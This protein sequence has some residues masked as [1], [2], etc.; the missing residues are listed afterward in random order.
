MTAPT[1]ENIVAA[2]RGWLGTPYLHQASVKGAGADCL[3]L[4][5]GVWRELYGGEP[6]APPPYAPDFNE[7]AFAAGGAEPLLEAARRHMAQTQ[8]PSPGDMLV[9]RVVREGPAKH[10]G[11]LTG[12]NHFIHAYAGRAV[13][14]SWLNR[15]WRIRVAGAFEFPGA[16]TWRS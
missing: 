11:I 1:R 3:G 14:E 6:E 12:A 10:C 2:A 9:F 4:V 8:N 13:I 15:W 16:Q 7:R 5:R